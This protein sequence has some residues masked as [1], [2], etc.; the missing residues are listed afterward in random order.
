MSAGNAIVDV[1][2]GMTG[3]FRRLQS[4]IQGNP[5]EHEIRPEVSQDALQK[6]IGQVEKASQKVAAAQQKA[7][8]ATGNVAVQEAKLQALVDKG[9][10]D[11]GRLAQARENVAKANRKAEE[12][13][14]NLQNAESGQRNAQNRV[15]RLQARMDTDEAEQET[16]TFFQRMNDRAR[17]F[18][19]S[20]GGILK[21]A[22][23]GA[24]AGVGILASQMGEVLERDKL[25]RSLRV[26]LDLTAEE[27]KR[28]GAIAG[29]VYAQNYGENM[30]A[31][32]EAVSAVA[33]SMS[34]IGDTTDAEMQ[35][36]TK[37]LLVMSESFGMDVNELAMSSS[38]LMRNG[39]AENGQQATDMLMTAFQRVPPAMRGELM[40]IIDE[41]GGYL[42]G[43]GFTGQEAMGLI[44]NASMDGA[45]GMDKMGDALKEFQIR[46][47]DMSTAS[48][49][50]YKTMGMDQTDMTNR[51]LAGGET[52]RVAF[53][54]IMAGLEG[55][56]DPAARSQAALALFGTP[57][58]DLGVD[59]IPMFLAQLNNA[60]SAMAGFEGSVEEAGDVL[61]GGPL[62]AVQ[63]FGREMQ[64]KIVGLLGDNVIPMLGDFSGVLEES[65]GNLIAAAASMVGLGG[66]VG[67]FEEAKGVFDQV[68][69]GV[70]G[71]KDSLVS[72]K[73][74]AVEA[75]GT[76]KDAGGWV[77]TQATAVGS[78]AKTAG[79][80]TL[81]AAKTAGAWTLAQ[82]KIAGGWALTA[83]KATASFIA[84]AVS[85]SIEAGKTALAW[86]LANGKIALSFV[87]SRGAM[88]ASAAAT[89][90]MTAAQWLLNAA[91][92]ANPIGV[93]IV[94]LLALVGAIIWAWNNVDW[95][96][97]AVV[98]AWQW[99]QN[100]VSW[101]WNNVIMPI[102]RW[103][104]DMFTALGNGIMWVWHNV[105]RVAWD[106]LLAGLRAV[107]DFFS[108]IWNNVIRPTWEALGNGIRW[109]V[110]NV[111]LPVWEGLKRGLGFLKDSFSEAVDFIGR[112]W[113]KIKSIAA[114]PAKFVVETVYN[115]GIR[116]AWNKVAGWLNLPELPEANL[117]DLGNYRTGG[118]LPG[119]TPGRDVHEFRSASGLRIGLSGGE[120]ILR[121]EAARAIGPAGVD[122][123]NAAARIGGVEAV[124]R[125]LG[126]YAGGGI[127]DSIVDKVQRFFPGMSITST[128][129]DTNDLHGAGKAVDFSNGTDTTPQ[130]QAAARFFH[131]NYGGMLAELIHYPLNGW[132]NIDEGRAYDFGAATNAQH[133]NHVH[134]A[135]HSPLPE[136]GSPITPISSGGGGGLFGWLRKRVGDAFNAVM[137]PIGNAIPDF[138]GGDIGKLPKMAFDKL[139]S[140]VYDFIVGKA[141]AQEAASGVGIGAYGGNADA[142]VREIVRAAMDRGLGKE[143]ASIGV[144]TAMVESALKMY[145]NASVPESLAYPHDAIGSDHD[146]VGLF[147]QRQAGWGTLAER[148][149]PYG[150]A[151]LFFNAMTRKFPNWRAM[152]PG[153]VAQGV[154]VSAYPGRYAQKMGEA[155]S[156]VDRVFDEGGVANG[157]GYMLKD[158]I[159]PERTLSP[160]QTRS[161]EALVP[162]LDRF[163]ASEAKLQRDIDRLEYMAN[164]GAGG[165]FVAQ[166]IENQYVVDPRENRRQV[167]QASKR[168]VAERTGL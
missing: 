161:F 142:Y 46:A 16:T 101:A 141:D 36:L 134:V 122:N 26:Q 120:A 56:Q 27:S 29:S 153:D 9:V 162:R 64:N 98:T 43:L 32:T 93:I 60:D 152:P 34:L 85:A 37:R 63:T 154:Q 97:N 25:Q 58:E 52:A 139:R 49:D 39:I 150:S 95:F 62:A 54:E 76:L 159:H 66:A 21:G 31:V 28:A 23:A 13:A 88:L 99:I 41:Y 81:N 167:R 116:A 83:L 3:Y 53:R 12:A 140:G 115:N 84:M 47:T 108:W 105:I 92:N 106:L 2:P 42:T 121:P 109:V 77:K 86:V 158:V 112:V 164:G 147:Q 72:A 89:G 132:Q 118:I 69:D 144:A 156:W 129:R 35:D 48:G 17:G 59:K 133:R 91:L 40:P 18:S 96:R 20:F 74:T 90:A 71:V 8:D 126:N 157:R 94:A 117:G 110:D 119:Y 14:R 22:A 102:L 67:G 7:A 30:G 135:A 33:G 87:I 113:D 131:D 103:F 82:L 114:K 70:V 44:V 130:M 75:W 143:G 51:L 45:I 138:G 55:I 151:A 166:K 163:E 79:S 11:A 111:V 19:S 137:D 6:A 168:V 65:D 57:L 80:A 160:R 165:E 78:F 123:L 15:V 148:M 155:R 124:R 107:G 104:G 127:V 10:T 4:E 149:N 146:S 136:P 100:A 61:G 1:M 125:E 73:D 68:K 24:V 145:A 128:Y 50:A 5:V 38:L